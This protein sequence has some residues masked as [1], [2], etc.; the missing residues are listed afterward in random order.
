MLSQAVPLFHETAT[1]VTVPCVVTDRN[2]MTINDLN[3]DDFR[4]YVDGSQG[5]STVY[6]LKA[7]L[8]PE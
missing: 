2:G 8:P 1:L 3:I 4:L 7:D 5:K 6:G